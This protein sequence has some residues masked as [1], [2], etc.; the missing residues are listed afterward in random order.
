[1]INIE[2][3]IKMENAKLGKTETNEDNKTLDH[4][5][6]PAIDG[7]GYLIWEKITNNTFVVMPN[8]GTIW[9]IIHSFSENIDGIKYNYF[10]LQNINN[11]VK[12]TAVS[13]NFRVLVVFKYTD[14]AYKI[15]LITG[16]N[17]NSWHITSLDD[18][19]KI[20]EKVI[21]ITDSKKT[22][23]I[24]VIKRDEYNNDVVVNVALSQLQTKLPAIIHDKKTLINLRKAN[25]NTFELSDISSY[26]DYATK[27]NLESNFGLPQ[28]V[29]FGR[30]IVAFGRPSSAFGRPSSAFGHPSDAFGRPSSAFGPQSSA[31]GPLSSAFS[32]QSSAFSPQS[33]FSSPSA[34][35]PH[36]AFSPQ[37]AVMV[38][39]SDKSLNMANYILNIYLE[40]SV[41]YAIYKSLDQETTIIKLKKSG[42]NGTLLNKILTRDDYD[43]ASFVNLRKKEM[44]QNIAETLETHLKNILFKLFGTDDVNKAK[45]QI[46]FIYGTLHKYEQYDMRKVIIFQSIKN[47]YGIKKEE[48]DNYT[49]EDYFDGMKMFNKLLFLLKNFTDISESRA[50]ALT[51]GVTG[52]GSP[53]YKNIGNKEILGKNRIIFKTAGSNKEYVKNKGIFISVSEYKKQ[54]KTAKSS[55]KQQNNK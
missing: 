43:K 40:L 19:D 18:N 20:F 12:I 35:A 14:T 15:G 53:V 51:F 22:D 38:V 55:K 49:S 26:A 23:I 25:N 44:V 16:Y 39:K 11:N 42:T 33:A 8:D 32:P 5:I 37:S 17:N 24:R 30:Q 45:K 2:G 54:Q 48:E 52:G 46:D 1:M 21:S 29:A 36:S 50:P 28:S 10:T 4:N 41:K 27:Y 6:T 31:F 3:S 34:P 13:Y 7:N 47:I 9:V